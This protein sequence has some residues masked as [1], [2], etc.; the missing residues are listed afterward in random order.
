MKSGWDQSRV[1]TV[2]RAVL[3]PPDSGRTS[4]VISSPVL[5]LVR[6]STRE[7]AGGGGFILIPGASPVKLTL[8]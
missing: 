8:D 5:N 3:I 4:L 1:V 7:P 6:L 2:T